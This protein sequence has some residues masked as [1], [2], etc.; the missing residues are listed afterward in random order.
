VRYLLDTDILSEPAKPRPSRKV[1]E[2]LAAR[3][4]EVATASPVWHELL[5]GCARLPASSR[6]QSLE[7][8][9]NEILAPILAIL[10]YDTAAAAWHAAER[11]RLEARG[12]TPPFVDGQIAAVARV[13]GLTLVT[14]NVGD[15]RD[16]DGLVVEDWT[17]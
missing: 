8:Y 4:D 16:F 13:R 10:P 2:R 5:Y 14:R 7:K 11:A 15:Y 3:R 6:R 12:R 1:M 9:L 17:A